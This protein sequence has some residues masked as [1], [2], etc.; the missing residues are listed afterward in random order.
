VQTSTSGRSGVLKPL[1]MRS[2]V[3]VFAGVRYREHLIDYLRQRAPVIEIPME[4]LGI[5]RQLQWLRR[6]VDRQAV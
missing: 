3:V 1:K 6:Q 5:G 2:R 4:R